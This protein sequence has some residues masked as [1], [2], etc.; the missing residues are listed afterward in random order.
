MGQ[1][2]EDMIEYDEI[3]LYKITFNTI[4]LLLMNILLIFNELLYIIF[5]IL[6]FLINNY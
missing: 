3:E 1:S 5:I 2:I 4:S 6:F